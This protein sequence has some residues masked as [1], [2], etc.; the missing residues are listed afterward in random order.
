[1]KLRSSP[2]HASACKSEV[3]FILRQTGVVFF[4]RSPDRAMA[5]RAAF[6]LDP[7][8]PDPVSQRELYSPPPSFLPLLSPD[9]HVAP[10]PGSVAARQ[11]IIRYFEGLVPPRGDEQMEEVC[12]DMITASRAGV[13]NGINPD[14]LLRACHICDQH[15]LR[16]MSR[17]MEPGAVQNRM[18]ASYIAN[19]AMY[20]TE[21]GQGES[22][23][24]ACN[25][26]LRDADSV[27]CKPFV[28]FIWHLTH[29]LARCEPYDGDTVY[30]FVNVDLSAQHLPGSEVTWS[31]FI[32]CTTSMDELR[33]AGMT[34][35]G[36]TFAIRLTTGRARSISRYSLMPIEGEVVLPVFSRFRVLEL[37]PTGNGRVLIRLEELPPRDPIINFDLQQ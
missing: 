5:A 34:G 12:A 31:S 20:T 21:L 17:Q 22:P 33:A 2:G 37:E 29:A 16:V 4:A 9:A 13:L 19:I 36:T 14:Q 24:A 18:L 6:P 27:Q 1:M 8:E 23:Y 35:S 11:L 3:I 26:A 25:R 10:I 7:R 32:S 30:R 15:G 28:P